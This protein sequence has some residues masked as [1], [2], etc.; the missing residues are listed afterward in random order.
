MY[1]QLPGINGSRVHYLLC[2]MSDLH[3]HLYTF[4]HRLQLESLQLSCI[5]SMRRMALE[6]RSFPALLRKIYLA[7][8]GVGYFGCAK[9][10]SSHTLRLQHV[11][12][13]IIYMN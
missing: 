12:I 5:C 13:V 11:F 7:K 8:L 1:I 2:C 4:S 6:L 9:L 3:T 10:C